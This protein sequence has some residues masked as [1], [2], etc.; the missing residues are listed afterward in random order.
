V[1]WLSLVSHHPRS[2]GV[3]DMFLEVFVCVSGCVCVFV[4]ATTLEPFEI[5]F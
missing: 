3:G 1:P 2:D 5:S 4:N